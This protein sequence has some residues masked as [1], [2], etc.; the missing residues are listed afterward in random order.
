MATREVTRAEEL[1]TGV[2]RRG[3]GSGPTGGNGRWKQ[4]RDDG[5]EERLA[6]ALGWFSLGLGL[7]Q[8]AAP[9]RMARMIGVH[10]NDRNRNAM[11]ALGVRELTS[12]IGILRGTEP[13]P[14]LWSRVGGDL[15]DLA[16]LG[17]AMNSD[18]NERDRLKRVAAA[19][20]GVTALDLFVSQQTGRRSSTTGRSSAAGRRLAGRAARK[21]GINVTRSITISRPVEEVYAFWR[22]FENLPRFMSHLESVRTLD[23]RRSNWKAR[24]PVGMTVEW[25]AEII[26]D[27]RNELIAWRALENA[28]V[29]NAGTVRFNPAA[30]DRGTE[31]TVELHYEPPAGKLG[32]AVAKLFGEE[33][34]QQVDGDLRRFKQVME[35]G[36]VVHSDSSIFRGPHPARPAAEGEMSKVAVPFTEGAA[37]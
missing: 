18:G 20:A 15:M 12:G 7:M 30:G 19:V 26:E 24:A 1:R 23:E 36:E 5:S 11:L 33:P 16:L 29:P 9:R 14:W 34:G 8:L 2:E 32:A 4:R 31:I 35:T 21:Q 3:Q 10:D 22:N 28:D 17:R 27:R 25:D 37:R 13:A 6:R